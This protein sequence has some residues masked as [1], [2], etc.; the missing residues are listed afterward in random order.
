MSDDPQQK[1]IIDMLELMRGAQFLDTVITDPGERQRLETQLGQRTSEL[2][3]EYE[4][5]LQIVEGLSKDDKRRKEFEK[6]TENLAKAL[7]NI[8][9]G[10]LAAITAFQKGDAIT[11]SAA[12]MDI[13]ASLAPMLGALSAAG[14][15]PGML[16]GAIFAMVGQILSF[17]APKSESLTSQIETLMRKL[18]AEEVDQKIKAVHKNITNYASA[19]RIATGR[20]SMALDQPG[21]QTRV[22]V[23]ILKDFNPIDGSTITDY[24]Q[25]TE[26]LEEELNQNQDRWPIILAAVCQAYTDL[27]VTVIT[28][29]SLIST[30]KMRARFDEAEKLPPEQKQEVRK[31]LT[32]LLGIAIARLI[33][34]GAI[35][36]IN[37]ETLKRLISVAQSR[38][39][40]W[41][42]G[43]GKGPLYAGTNIRQ[44]RFEKL[45]DESKRMA[46]AV[47][48]KDM[49]EPNPLYHVFLLEP[50]GR[51]Y[52]KD[53]S[54]PYKYAGLF[55]ELKCD[56]SSLHALTDIW[57]TTGAAHNDKTDVL[58]YSA[59]DKAIRGF[60]LSKDKKVHQSGYVRDV[61]SNLVSVRVVHNPKSFVDDPDEA[62][63]LSSVLKGI[64][65]L[66]YGGLENS[67]AIYAD[68]AGKEG[69]VR[70]PWGSYSGL[71]VDQHYLWVFK[72]RG[73]ACATHASVMRCLR[74]KSQEPRWMEHCPKELL[75]DKSYDRDQSK[76]KLPEDPL[77]G[78][79]DL[80]PCDDGTLAAAMYTRSVEERAIHTGTVPAYVYEFIDTNAVYSA[81]YHTDLKNGTI[82]VEWT[83]I[84]GENLAVRVQKLPVFCWSLIESLTA[85]LDELAPILRNPPRLV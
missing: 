25:V 75:Y 85:T 19:L 74:G 21:L 78:L 58:F 56:A 63:E 59:K 7:P 46:V 65:Y 26:W 18:Q 37:W 29:F 77:L 72:S 50:G 64:D 76:V 40:L 24:W 67:S 47:S 42:N 41:Y 15:P 52:Y 9:K 61:K 49:A 69:Y 31:Q 60:V 71:G 73:F 4:K 38:G 30:D 3:S 80:C 22:I 79:V 57:A 62:A 39:M 13:C 48:R 51:T 54:S 43:F 84:G 44:G 36:A 82:A 66:V 20:I 53:I 16:V 35:N 55:Q 32:K 81:V 83:K 14:G 45:A 34:Y 68:G 8:T 70:S 33:E 1:Y 5:E 27:L 10:T 28:I 11:G 17:F 6:H 12:V 23:Q 2:R